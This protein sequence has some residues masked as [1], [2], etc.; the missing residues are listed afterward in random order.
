MNIHIAG[1]YSPSNDKFWINRSDKPMTSDDVPPDSIPLTLATDTERALVALD[2]IY[3]NLMKT[4][5]QFEF[6]RTEFTRLGGV[7]YG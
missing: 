7:I 4:R 3:D 1:W 5:K 6:L 2:D